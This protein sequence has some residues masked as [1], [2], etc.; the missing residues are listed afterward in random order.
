MRKTTFI[1]LFTTMTIFGFSQEDW[2]GFNRFRADNVRI[3][4]SGDFPEVVF[5]GNSITEYWAY[6]HPDFFSEHHYC[7]RGIGGQT[8]TQMLARFTAD[9]VNLHPKAVVIMA[10]TNDV[11]HNTYWVEPTKVVE[12]VVAIK[13]CLKMYVPDLNY[14]NIRSVPQSNGTV[15]VIID[16][17]YLGSTEHTYYI[18]TIYSNKEFKVNS[19]YGLEGNFPHNSKMVI[20]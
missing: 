3:A 15:D 5:M 13:Y 12:N 8:S 14:T 1:I 9:V 16:Y 2:F 4:E 11:A 18:V 17:H 19:C 7:G 6:Y 20:Q 10:G